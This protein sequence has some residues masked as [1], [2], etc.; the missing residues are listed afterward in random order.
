ML[1]STL[2]IISIFFLAK[3]MF[4]EKEGLISALLL[5]VS[6]YSINYSQEAKMY[7]MIWFLSILSFMY[8]FLYV[9]SHRTRHLILL[10]IFSSATIYTMYLG[11]IFLLVQNILFFCLYREK[12]KT[13]IAAN[14][15]IVLS[16]IPWWYFAIYN[17]TNKT[18][19]KWV[20][21]VD[22]QDFFQRLFSFVSGIRIGDSVPGEAWLLIALVLI[23]FIFSIYVTTSKKQISSVMS[24]P[25]LFSWP[26]ISIVIFI[27]MDKCSHNTLIFRYLGFIH[28]PVIIIFSIGITVFYH[29]RLRWAGNLVAIFLVASAFYFHVVPFHKH[30]LK[31]HREYWAE[32]I[33]DLCGN[34]DKNSLVLTGQ[35][36]KAMQYY[37]KCFKGDIVI[38]SPN[39]IT[40]AYIH[41]NN[42]NRKNYH[43]IFVLYR[44][45]RFKRSD[46]VLKYQANEIR[47]GQNGYIQIPLNT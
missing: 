7:A 36:N 14:I 3:N 26:V 27:I 9:N 13:W 24:Y 39:K 2:S 20:K 12:I 4:S 17:L 40:E 22:Y 15:L 42:F 30:G 11:F 34:A 10:G 28:I 41:E 45:K 46:W 35:G 37:G 19:V 44:N 33:N 43:T 1:F 5:S 32:L 25:A 18:G 6:S 8:F 29:V 38:V 16:Y 23:A 47:K 21:G 31:I